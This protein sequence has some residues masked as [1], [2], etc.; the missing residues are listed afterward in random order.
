MPHPG[1]VQA[2]GTEPGELRTKET[3][4]TLDLVAPD[5]EDCCEGIGRDWAI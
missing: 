5:S 4:G 3:P 2:R 1:P